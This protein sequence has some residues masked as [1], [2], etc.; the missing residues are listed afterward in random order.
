MSPEG[1]LSTP[2]AVEDN[3]LDPGS[4]IGDLWVV[5]ATLGSG[6][7]GSVLLCHNRHAPRILAAI[8]L[9]AAE[10]VGMA[11]ARSRFAREAELLHQL[12]HPNIVKVRNVRLEGP[13]PH[14]EMEYVDGPS[15]E[16]RIQAGPL[17]LDTALLVAEQIASAVRYLHRHGVCHRDLK[18]ANVLLWRKTIVKLV[19]FGLALES[20]ADRITEVGISFGTVSYAPPEW[21]TP[22]QLDPRSW[23]LYAIGVILY[24]MLTGSVA[25]P[26]PFVGTP[27]QT[28]I[29]VMS[30]KQTVAC[31][32]PGERFPEPLRDLVRRL[33]ALR[34]SDR[35]GT[36]REV[37]HA[38][39]AMLA[40]R[41]INPDE[42]LLRALGEDE[43][44]SHTA[45]GLAGRAFGLGGR[46]EHTSQPDEQPRTVPP[47]P[48]RRLPIPALVATAASV[49]W[50]AGVS[51][52]VATFGG[53]AWT[54]P[55]TAPGTPPDE[56]VALTAATCDPGAATEVVHDSGP[57]SG[58]LVSAAAFAAWLDDHKDWAPGRAVRK[59]Q[60]TDGYLA[61]FDAR[62]AGKEPIRGV[63]YGAAAA[64]CADRG[65]VAPVEAQPRQ[66][67]GGL[68]QEWRGSPAGP[69][70]R[71]RGG[72]V[73]SNVRSTWV[74]SN[75]GFRC[76]R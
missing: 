13:T 67:S 34:L 21:V 20:W 54:S 45:L 56:P 50:I 55:P 53:L 76:A 39:Q 4:L 30:D 15:L 10:R 38:L 61:D 27:R 8:K 58:A 75:A 41:G 72:T 70:L 11:D 66:W 12:D 35:P 22:E 69:A 7:M 73:T 60:A 65:G 49:T 3:T 51:L 16:T 9:L 68:A 25:F 36:A 26:T 57:M 59:G 40:E 43:M 32:D 47:A 29:R 23:D 64:Y 48:P 42:Q 19:D 1:C 18:P 37:V 5:R 6:S 33:T 62:E 17:P 46:A 52:F 31:L 44:R 28:A 71:T 63:S 74:E 2:A 24:E 14:L